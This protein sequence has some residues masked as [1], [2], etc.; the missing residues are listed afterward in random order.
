M[1]Q[2]KKVLSVMLVLVMA[3]GLLAG[4]K[5]PAPEKKVDTSWYKDSE[6]TFT[7][8][9]A[10][11]LMGLAE[12]AKEKDFAG[13]TIKLGADIKL[14]DYSEE[15]L[16]KWRL[17]TTQPDNIWTPLG[18]ADLPF[19]GIIDGQGHK[20]SGLYVNGAE[21][22]T[23]FIGTASYDVELTNI[24]FVDGYIMNTQV[25]TGIIGYGIVKK[26]ENVYTNLFV[27]SY[28]N[29]VGG[30]VGAYK[31][32]YSDIAAAEAEG[33]VKSYMKINNCWFDG[34]I[35]GGGYAIGGAVGLTDGGR[36]RT[37]VTN[38]LST[39]KIIT[40]RE[41]E[42]AR[43][44]AVFGWVNNSA[45]YEFKNCLSLATIESAFTGSNNMV[46][47]VMGNLGANP[48]YIVITNCYGVGDK[49]CGLANSSG[50]SFVAPEGL[51]KTIDEIKAL[52]IATALP[53]LEG[54]EASPWEAVSGSTPVLKSL[55]K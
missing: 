25:G 18:N 51:L 55:K 15:I 9:K 23:G 27:E 39:G 41:D 20:I 37:D 43:A 7:L 48:L 21:K 17:G 6:T 31:G 19:A 30:F 52:D 36:G 22:G 54:E 26:I 53:K 2:V 35:S 8:T 49:V 45:R 29:G 12:L 44:S 34:T 32:S 42:Y 16:S 11:Q 28:G 33:W 13:K 5:K 50:A 24:K 10:N 40:L 3:L 14:N 46:G 1:K 38:F 47:T 4:C